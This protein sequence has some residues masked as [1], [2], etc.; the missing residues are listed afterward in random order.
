M[1]S[2]CTEAEIIRFLHEGPKNKEFHKSVAEHL[3]RC[4]EC[5]RLFV[6]ISEA[7]L[8]EDN[9]LRPPKPKKQITRGG[10]HLF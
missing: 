2:H 7:K 4:Q 1:R 8:P 10:P 3:A 9:N 6:K 5:S